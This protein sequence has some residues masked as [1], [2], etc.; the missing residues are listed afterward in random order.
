MNTKKFFIAVFFSVV[1]MFAM[2]HASIAQA[3]SSDNVFGEAWSDGMGWVSFNNCASSASC[4]GTSYGVTMNSSTGN[5]SGEA[6]AD[7]FGWVSFNSNAVTNCGAQPNV[8]LSTGAFS[9]FAWAENTAG[10]G[11]DGCIAL[12]AGS[13]G[14]GLQ[15]NTSTGAVTGTAWSDLNTMWITPDAS[16]LITPSAFSLPAPT[17]VTAVCNASGN[18]VTMSWTAPA[19]YNTFYT[20]AQDPSSTYVLYNDAATG[21]SA[22]FTSTPGLTYNTWVHTR[23]PST[24]AWS[25]PVYAAVTCTNPIPTPVLSVSGQYI[26]NPQGPSMTRYGAGLTASW[27]AV[28]NATSCTLEGSAVSVNGG[29]IS[30]NASGWTNNTH[31]FVLACSG[32][33]GNGSST[34]TVSYPPQPS[35]LSTVCNA[36]STQVT[37]NWTAPAGYNMFYTRAQDPSNNYVL[38]NDQHTGTTD[39]FPVTPGVTYN[40]WVHAEDPA[41]GA[42]SNAINSLVTCPILYSITASSSANGTVTP[43]GVTKV[44]SGASQSY[45]ITPNSGYAANTLT[46]DGASVAVVNPYV[47]TNVTTNHTISA[48]FIANPPPGVGPYTITASSGPNGTVTPAGATTVVKGASQTY[49]IKPSAGYTVATVTIDGVSVAVGLSHT[50]SNVQSDHTIN[51]TFAST[52]SCGGPCPVIPPSTG[53]PTG[54]T[55]IIFIEK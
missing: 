39:S 12:G 54:S 11:W 51:A 47:F 29:S 27:P 46:V 28:A 25:N 23:D 20:R 34:V 8:S 45:A 5:L 26:S 30:P 2:G 49:N 19:G 35:N 6:W 9:G 10:T 1:A 42:Y 41:T 24:G 15:A 17:N 50:F 14:Q 16:M 44:A 31:N 33:A 55:G 4:S 3:S 43:S 18:Q 38:Y 13:G 37:M 7:N 53:N 52:G 22:T 32:P 48:T 40:A 36:S 21:T